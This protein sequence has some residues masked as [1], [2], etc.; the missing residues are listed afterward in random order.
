M[1]ISKAIIRQ[2]L[3]GQ[4]TLVRDMLQNAV[5]AT[6]IEKFRDELPDADALF[7]KNIVA[8]GGREKV[9]TRHTVHFKGRYAPS[10][11]TTIG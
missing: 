4:S 10:N 8:Q 3:D 11:T 9:L 6:A 5:A 7:E 1:S 2:K